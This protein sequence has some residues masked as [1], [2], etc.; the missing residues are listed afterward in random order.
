M[1]STPTAGHHSCGYHKSPSLA[2]MINYIPKTLSPKAAGIS[3]SP[4]LLFLS[5]L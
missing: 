3:R 4:F 2:G 1:G 5:T